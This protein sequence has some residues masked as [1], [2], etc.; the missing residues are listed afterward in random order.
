MN[1]FNVQLKDLIHVE[2]NLIPGDLC[3][4][5]LEVIESREWRSHDWYSP[6]DNSYGSEETMELDVQNI[7]PELQELFTPL[8]I[9][10]CNAYSEKYS[11]KG[12]DRTQEVVHKFS[13]LRFN[14][15]S[16]GQIMRQHIDHIHSIFDGQDKGIHVLSLILNLNEDYEGADLFFWDN[17]IVKPGK[18][19]VVI[20]PS[21]F[22]FPHRVTEAKK[23]KRYS[24]VC[25]AW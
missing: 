4:H 11:F 7:T 2:R 8:I 19:D 6:T 17:H 5:T 24:A 23:G 13:S 3:D 10:A 9:E 20:F 21:L 14:R 18:G 25:W 12:C 16:N 1:N 22:L 15:Y